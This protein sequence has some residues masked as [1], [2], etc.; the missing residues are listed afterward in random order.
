MITAA[1]LQDADLKVISDDS[2]LSGF[3]LDLSRIFG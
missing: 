1:K 3:A 2:V